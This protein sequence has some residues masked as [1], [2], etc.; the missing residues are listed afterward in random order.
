MNWLNT[1]TMIAH[2]FLAIGIIGLVLIQ[3]G[4]GADAGAGFGSGAS[5]T[6]FG[7]RGSA[8]FLS[9][10]TGIFAGLFFITSLTLAYFSNHGTR[11]DVSVTDQDTAVSASSSS[12]SA[13]PSVPATST[14]PQV[15]A[16][17]A[18]AEQNAAPT[19]SSSSTSSAPAK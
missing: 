17:V 3:R 19:L 12:L 10:T 6:V 11:A 4:K 14:V 15:P 1:F 9:R 13:A 2:L 18:P 5:G 8:N 16:P 7:A